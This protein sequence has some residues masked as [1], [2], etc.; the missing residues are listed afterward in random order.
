[1]VFVLV[2]AFAF[3]KGS[4]SALILVFGAALSVCTGYRVR[5]GKIV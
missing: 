5:F 3:E 2:S 4:E 1:M